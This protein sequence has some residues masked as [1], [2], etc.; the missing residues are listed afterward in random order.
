MI[1]TDYN[2]K[3]NL[4]SASSYEQVLSSIYAKQTIH[5]VVNETAMGIAGFGRVKAAQPAMC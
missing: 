5:G 2:E 1:I 3:E 4:S